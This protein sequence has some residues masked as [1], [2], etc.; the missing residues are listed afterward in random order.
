VNDSTSGSLLICACYASVPSHL[1]LETILKSLPM[2]YLIT[3]PTLVEFPEAG[4]TYCTV[5]SLF[6]TSSRA[7]RR[8]I[9]AACNGKS[10][11]HYLPEI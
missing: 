11:L 4:A 6:Q 9:E 1:L 10:V 5:L 2:R 3:P 7:P 8:R